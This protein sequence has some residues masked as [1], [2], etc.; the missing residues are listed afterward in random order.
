[1]QTRNLVRGFKLKTLKNSSKRKRTLEEI[2]GGLKGIKHMKTLINPN[3][4]LVAYKGISE[5]IT[6]RKIV[7]KELQAKLKKQRQKIK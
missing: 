5:A 6:N 1:M 2:R 3:M 7:T 4:G